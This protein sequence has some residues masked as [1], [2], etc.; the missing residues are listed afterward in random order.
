M[1]IEL[2]TVNGFDAALRGMRNPKNSWDKS[3][4]TILVRQ[5]YHVETRHLPMVLENS[6]SDYFEQA[7]IGPKDLELACKLIKA[8]S[9]H[10][11]FLRMIVVWVDM[12]LPRYVWAEFDTYKI[13][14]VRNSCS[15]I[16]KLGSA[17]LTLEDFEEGPLMPEYLNPVIDE[18][19]KIAKRMKEEQSFAWRRTMKQIL[20]ESFL[21]KATVMLNYEVLLSMFFQ[22]RNHRLKEW[23]VGSPG[24]I[25]D[26]IERLPYMNYFIEAATS[27]PVD[28]GEVRIDLVKPKTATIAPVKTE[29]E[30]RT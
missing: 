24:S 7:L 18:L 13:G 8:G 14:V 3:D 27:K 21:Q 28:T 30:E 17:E 11:K 4:T 25:C 16:H 26:W 5:P 22:R 20:P 19:N 2:T 12:T 15:T 23:N 9:E 1:K 29:E 10:R 6:G